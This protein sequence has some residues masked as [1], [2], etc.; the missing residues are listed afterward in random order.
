MKY[1]TNDSVVDI[2]VL[3]GTV[4]KV[5]LHPKDHL[6]ADWLENYK[7]FKLLY[8]C[9]PEVYEADS[10]SITMEYISGLDI[11]QWLKTKH[12]TV[13]N[14]NF[15]IYEVMNLINSF[16]EYSRGS[17]LFFYHHDLNPTNILVDEKDR[18]ILIEPDEIF[19]SKS[20]KDRYLGSCSILLQHIQTH[21]DEQKYKYKGDRMSIKLRS[22]QLTR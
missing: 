9:V 7:K 14:V 1:K 2:D 20:S 5:F 22:K 13:K 11:C 17:N 3:N 15:V 10:H 18:V 4:N 8:D 19:L 6:D 12:Y 21:M 16:A